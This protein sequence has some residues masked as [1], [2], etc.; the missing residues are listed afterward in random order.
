MCHRCASSQQQTNLAVSVRRQL[1]AAV[2][3]TIVIQTHAA[4]HALHEISGK[5]GPSCQV[6]TKGVHCISEEE[7]SGALSHRLTVLSHMAIWGSKTV[8]VLPRNGIA[9]S[10]R[11]WSSRTYYFSVALAS[12]SAKILLL[13]LMRNLT[14]RESLRSFATYIDAA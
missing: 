12:G 3:A 10:P 5:P 13:I 7:Q 9:T 11:T 4:C 1:Q 14:G 6:R 8:T 2:K